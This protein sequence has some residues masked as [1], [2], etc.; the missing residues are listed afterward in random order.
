M[1]SWSGMKKINLEAAKEYYK[2]ENGPIVFLLYDDGTEA[3]AT[4]IAGIL[5]HGEH[6]GEFGIEKKKSRIELIFNDC[7]F[8]DGWAE[9]YKVTL[10]MY[11]APEA[12]QIREQLQEIA[13]GFWEEQ[14]CSEDGI[15]K[16]LR[17]YQKSLD[18]EYE[19]QSIPTVC[20][21]GQKFTD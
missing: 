4:S 6:G 12:T 19:I 14:E 17:E 3:E 13:N 21:G 16:I 5:Y 9:A 8:N 1:Y 15:R 10:T 18:F 2:T 7:L 20:F 11:D